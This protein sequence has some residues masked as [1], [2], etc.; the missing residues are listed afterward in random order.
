MQP[1]RI[2]KIKSLLVSALARQPHE[3]GAYLDYA[4]A[5][6][7]EL[8]REE[9]YHLAGGKKTE[10]FRYQTQTAH[11]PN[12]SIVDRQ[13]VTVAI[14]APRG[15]PRIGKE[16]GKYVIRQKIAEGGMGIVYLALDT[17]LGR[18]V[19]VKILPEYF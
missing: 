8:R 16:F 1:E 11:I 18:E 19:A 6:D 4:C 7:R 5:G 12:P 3:R 14:E 9:E 13:A 10:Q 2:E 15:D 17:Q